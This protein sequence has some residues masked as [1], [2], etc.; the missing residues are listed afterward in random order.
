MYYDRPNSYKF[1]EDAI[2]KDKF[3]WVTESVRREDIDIV[4]M[5]AKPNDDE[6]RRWFMVRVQLFRKYN[7][8]FRSPWVELNMIIRL[9][10]IQ[11]EQL[12]GC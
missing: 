7:E 10:R 12:I 1:Q 8:L 11:R 4:T 9:K 3:A 2:T 5:A 6:C